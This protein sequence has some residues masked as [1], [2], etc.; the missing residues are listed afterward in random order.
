[1]KSATLRIESLRALG[2]HDT[3]GPVSTAIPGGHSLQIDRIGS[4]N[5]QG[6][7][8]SSVPNPPHRCLTHQGGSQQTRTR[9]QPRDPGA[10]GK[11][12]ASPLSFPPSL[13]VQG[14]PGHRPAQTKREARLSF[15]HA[16]PHHCLRAPLPQ[17][18]GSREGTSPVGVPIL[19]EVTA[20]WPCQPH[21]SPAPRPRDLYSPAVTRSLRPTTAPVTAS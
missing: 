16:P 12:G 1:M 21:I 3:P 18:S 5:A 13:T 9:S 7:I 17:A 11:R 4:A 15:S 19:D 14:R 2:T 6:E 20:K 10:W 8:I